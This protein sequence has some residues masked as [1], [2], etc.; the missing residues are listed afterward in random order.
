[1][2]LLTRVLTGKEDGS[3][4]QP[5]RAGGAL[6]SGWNRA[7]SC[8]SYDEHGRGLSPLWPLCATLPASPRDQGHGGQ[9]SQKVRHPM[10]GASTTHEIDPP[11]H[12]PRAVLDAGGE[13]WAALSAAVERLLDEIASGAMLEIISLEPN[14]RADVPAWCASAGHEIVRMLEEGNAT[15]FWIRKG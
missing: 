6:E 9:E 15:R 4:G 10:E 7:G 13:L 12:A 1:M 3:L 11:S 2:C 14:I 5:V 8:P